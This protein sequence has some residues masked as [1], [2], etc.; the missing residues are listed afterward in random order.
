[1]GTDKKKP[2]YGTPGIWKIQNYSVKAHVTV[3]SVLN[4]MK[5]IMTT[6]K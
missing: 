1:M 6:N 3:S 2:F 5:F 4:E